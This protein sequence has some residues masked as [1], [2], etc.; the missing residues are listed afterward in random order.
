V[1][2][3]DHRAVLMEMYRAFNGRDIDTAIAHLGPSVD[4]PNMTTGG[5]VAGRTG[6]RDYW[7]RQWQESNPRVEPMKIDA[8]D[9]GTVHVLVDQLVRGLDGKVLVNRQVEHVYEFEGPFISRMTIVDVP[10]A[11]DDEDDEDDTP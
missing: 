1:S 3:D 10:E 6:V 4:W 9:D 8:A 5:R 7:L 11:V 2:A